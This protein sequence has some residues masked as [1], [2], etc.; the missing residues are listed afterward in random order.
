MDSVSVTGRTI[1]AMSS[2]TSPSQADDGNKGQDDKKKPSHT[3]L[4]AVMISTIFLSAMATA[5][6][7]V[8]PILPLVLCTKTTVRSFYRKVV[9]EAESLWLGTAAGVISILGGT[10]VYVEGASGP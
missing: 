8:A 10:K 5:L 2:S 6:M 1:D 3:M 7:V 9:R 4:G